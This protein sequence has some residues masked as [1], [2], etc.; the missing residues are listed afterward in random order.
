MTLDNAS[1]LESEGKFDL[2]LEAYKSINLSNSENSERLYVA[3]SIAACLYYLGRYE[4]AELEFKKILTNYDLNDSDK[5]DL[6]D[7][8]H[9]CYLYGNHPKLAQ[10]YFQNKIQRNEL[11]ESEKIW[12][13]WYIGQYYSL[14]E[15]HSESFIAYHKCFTIADHINHN[16]K[17][18][19][20]AHYILSLFYMNS[21]NQALVEYEIFKIKNPSDSSCGL[22]NIA[23]GALYKKLGYNNWEAIF[24]NG[25][26]EAKKSKYQENIDIA[27][28]IIRNFG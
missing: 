1:Q 10:E 2:A 20:F 7:C 6:N 22:L 24:Q 15:N 9:I 3:R 28:Q 19:F 18:F 17:A 11:P 12:S 16:R 13:L 23:I 21:L 14:E 4:E 25:I 27:N 5:S 26:N 8:L